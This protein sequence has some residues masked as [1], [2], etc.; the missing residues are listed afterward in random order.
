MG[1]PRVSEPAA[2]P[3]DDRTTAGVP[4]RNCRIGIDSSCSNVVG[5]PN[6]QLPRY[7][8][9]TQC[10][11]DQDSPNKRGKHAPLRAADVDVVGC[12]RI[13]VKNVSVIT[14]ERVN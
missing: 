9:E 2:R 5:I 14:E 7:D 12:E 8:S 1:T 11:V 6:G 10:I 3:P 13:D 4:H